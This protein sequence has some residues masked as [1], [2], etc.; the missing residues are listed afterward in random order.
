M[1]LALDLNSW[2]WE[3]VRRV[4]YI[5][6]FVILTHAI[7]V[8]I[9]T[10]NESYDVNCFSRQSFGILFVMYSAVVSSVTFRGIVSASSTFRSYN[11]AFFTSLKGTAHHPHYH[12]LSSSTS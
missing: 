2:V 8:Y 5:W 4:K 12:L 9:G 3:G 10:R 1:I 11:P 7:D 6:A